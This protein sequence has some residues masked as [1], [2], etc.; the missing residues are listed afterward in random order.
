MV[1]Y[2]GYP[3]ENVF[4]V[5]V[6]RPTN[7]FS[8]SPKRLKPSSTTSSPVITIRSWADLLMP[9][10]SFPPGRVFWAIICLPIVGI[11]PLVSQ[12]LLAM[13]KNTCQFTSKMMKRTVGEILKILGTQVHFLW[14]LQ[15]V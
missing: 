4:F 15:E 12:I 5:W 10:L 3:H 7:E 6:P 8:V 9:M 11:I 14:E 2:S 13:Q 1:S